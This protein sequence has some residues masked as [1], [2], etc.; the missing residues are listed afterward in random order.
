MSNKLLKVLLFIK[1]LYTHK[2]NVKVT[3]N[4][5]ITITIMVLLHIFITIK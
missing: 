5:D 2:P 3:I 4:I 1:K